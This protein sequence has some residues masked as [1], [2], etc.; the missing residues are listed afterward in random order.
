MP[1]RV[2]GA[3]RPL[4]ATI[5][6]RSRPNRS[7]ATWSPAST[8]PADVITVISQLWILDSG[9]LL[10][11]T[12]ELIVNRIRQS[13]AVRRRHDG[14]FGYVP[15]Q[16]RSCFVELRDEIGIIRNVGVPLEQ[17]GDAAGQFLR[18]RIEPP[19]RRR[20]RTVVRVDQIIAA[21]GRTGEVDWRNSR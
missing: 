17:R 9:G 13:G 10:I 16:D 20:H 11:G 21:V 6:S 12:A 18:P 14:D 4:R 2:V 15:G 8:P 7:F 3:A 5:A 1:R 19:D